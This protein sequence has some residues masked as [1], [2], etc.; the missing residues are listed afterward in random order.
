MCGHAGAPSVAPV[1]TEQE[2]AIMQATA[3]LVVLGGLA[4]G[5]ALHAP[6]AASAATGVY[7]GSNAARVEL[8]LETDG[9]GRRLKSAV[10]AVVTRCDD[11]DSYPITADV[12][13]VR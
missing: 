11:G 10:M 12:T 7:G 1:G 13:V 8:V 5:A 4:A 6:P 2:G 9:A 3:V